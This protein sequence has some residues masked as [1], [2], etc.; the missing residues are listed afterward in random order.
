[1]AVTGTLAGIMSLPTVLEVLPGTPAAA[2]GI[3]AGDELPFRAM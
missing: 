1:M 3:Q 2:A